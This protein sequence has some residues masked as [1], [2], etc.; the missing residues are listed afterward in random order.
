MKALLDICVVC[1]MP[2]V[3]SELAARL[4]STPLVIRKLDN[5]TY[6]MQLYDSAERTTVKAA[7]EGEN[8][9]YVKQQVADYWATRCTNSL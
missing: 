5:G 2:H 3:V 7:V 4:P 8:A 1:R 6:H 9:E